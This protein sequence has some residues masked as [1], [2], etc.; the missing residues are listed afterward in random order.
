[1]KVAIIK[2]LRMDFSSET[3]MEYNVPNIM[4]FDKDISTPMLLPD[5]VKIAGESLCDGT[6]FPSGNID[7]P[8]S[9]AKALHKALHIES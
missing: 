4:E 9:K 3:C 8:P 1:M 5:V 6:L 2:G 7:E